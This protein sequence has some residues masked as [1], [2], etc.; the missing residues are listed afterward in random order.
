M[1]P[2]K[3]PPPSVIAA[4]RPAGL[5]R[6]P[7]SLPILTFSKCYRSDVADPV[8][9]QVIGICFWGSHDDRAAGR[10]VTPAGASPTPPRLALQRYHAA[11]PSRDGVSGAGQTAGRLKT[12]S[13]LQCAA[14]LSRHKVSVLPRD[15][16]GAERWDAEIIFGLQRHH[17][18]GIEVGGI[19]WMEFDAV[20]PAF[21]RQREGLRDGAPPQ[22]WRE[23]GGARCSRQCEFRERASSAKICAGPVP[24]RYRLVAE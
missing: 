24:V 7:S 23:L 21:P 3:K 1:V 14:P 2:Q 8:Q 18:D 17:R 19:P 4:T 16:A 9:Q 5:E 11:P 10:P 13:R 22:E 20:V 15:H 6:C 12:G